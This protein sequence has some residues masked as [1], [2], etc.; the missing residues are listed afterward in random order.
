MPE[1]ETS[2]SSNLPSRRTVDAGFDWQGSSI[3][4]T[5]T[6]HG[7]GLT[8]PWIA[9]RIRR[10]LLDLRASEGADSTDSRITFW[11][12]GGVRQ[13][14]IGG[15]VTV[16]MLSDGVEVTAGVSALGQVVPPLALLAGV[17]LLWYRDSMSG[18]AAAFFGAFVLL[19][20]AVRA[21]RI[22]GLLRTLSRAGS[23]L[24]EHDT[25]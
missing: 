10:A 18:V 5:T 22:A 17:D 13:A 6:V 12:P 21:G 25:A 24:G 15:V 3:V 16:T 1:L 19:G 4:H 11:Q 7:S 9:V 23:G 14:G 8:Q 2:A 20:T